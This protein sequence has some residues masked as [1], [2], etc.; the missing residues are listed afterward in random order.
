[1]KKFQRIGALIVIILLL[2]MYLVLFVAAISG[3][4]KMQSLFR[5]TLGM[6]IALPILLYVFIL[7]LRMAQN[8]KTTLEEPETQ[9]DDESVSR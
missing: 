7:F 6:T 2:S 8:K 3:S 5:I 4:E 9:D 1:M